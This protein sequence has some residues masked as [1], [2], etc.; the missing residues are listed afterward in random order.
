[1]E[2]RAPAHR[3]PVPEKPLPKSASRPQ[4]NQ[5]VLNVSACSK[6]LIYGRPQSQFSEE[7]FTTPGPVP[8][9]AV[10]GSERAAAPSAQKTMATGLDALR[11]L[12]C[13]IKKNKSKFRLGPPFGNRHSRP[14]GTPPMV[15]TKTHLA[16][17]YPA[18]SMEASPH[19]T[20]V[21]LWSAGGRR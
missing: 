11:L 6:A 4:R 13:R 18:L 2:K 17:W 16:D 12:F 1:M 15:E 9:C 10:T 19:K 5:H 7:L 8:F 20:G 3:K 14:G 21:R